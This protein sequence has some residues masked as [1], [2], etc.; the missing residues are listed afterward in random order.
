MVRQTESPIDLLFP[1]TRHAVLGT[2]LLNPERAWYRSDL[3]KHL[4]VRPS[5]LQ[6]ELDTL[7]RAG[8]LTRR[9]DGNRSYFQA[10]ASCPFFPELRGLMEKTA[11]LIDL[12]REGLEPLRSRITV[13]FVFGSVARGQERSESDV[14]L[15]VVGAVGQKDLLPILRHLEE[16]LG[17]PVNAHTYTPAE[18]GEKVRSGHRFLASVLDRKKLFVIGTSDDLDTLSQPG[19]P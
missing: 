10:N 13:A 9:R 12:V 18:F 4:R 3:A 17:R 15:M 2:L 8:V 19:P 5:S 14:D 16:R 7:A 6:R 11:G 1:R